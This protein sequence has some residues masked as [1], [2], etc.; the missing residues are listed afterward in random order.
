MKNLEEILIVDGLGILMMVVLLHTR[1]QNR[2]SVWQDD[3]IFDSMIIL[4]MLGCAIE[5]LSFPIDTAVFPGARILNYL[6]N[7][8]CFIDTVTIGYFWCLY[9][10]L[11]L[12]RN[13][14]RTKRRAKQLLPFLGI[15]IA[16]NLINAAGW[17]VLFSVSADNV[18]RRG[19]LVSVVYVILMLYFIVSIVTVMRF[20]RNGSRLRFF[21]V[22]QFVVPCVVGVL[23]QWLHYGIAIGWTCVALAFMFVQMQ[24]HSEDLLV[25]ALS[26]LF[27]RRYLD[28]VLRQA[29]KKL[30]APM[31]GILLDI[32]DFKQINDVYGHAVGDRAICAMGQ[33]LSDAIGEDAVAIRY[34]GDEFIV[35][36]WNADRKRLERL[37]ERI[38]RGIAGFNKATE[39]PYRLSAA[40]GWGMLNPGG[41][42]EAFFN[43]MDSNMYKVKQQ[44]H[45]D[46]EGKR[47]V[48]ETA[49]H[50]EVSFITEKN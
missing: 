12:Y 21:P 36:L 15:D 18:Y 10:D 1:R 34:A 26:G 6:T 3:R 28:G 7:S 19:P 27:N 4:T 32:N 48:A 35:L 13:P 31:G 22:Y 44:F 8:L 41:S 11:R 38:S 5:A 23:M 45:Q 2:E 29:E 20:R 33:V 30:R 17:G 46:E 16:L 47:N 37:M 24:S 40:Q 14:K 50:A 42:V 25:D 9:V 43:Q 39:E 49:Q